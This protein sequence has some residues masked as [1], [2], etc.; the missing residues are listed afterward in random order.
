MIKVNESEIKT[1]S[2]LSTLLKKTGL[3]SHNDLK[4][5]AIVEFMYEKAD[6]FVEIDFVKSVETV[7]ENFEVFKM[8][9]NDVHISKYDSKVRKFVLESL[10]I[11]DIEDLSESIKKNYNLDF[12]NIL[13]GLNINVES[14]EFK[15]LVESIDIST[16]VDTTKVDDVYNQVNEAN[17]YYNSI[18]VSKRSTVENEFGVLLEKESKLNSEK[19]RF[20]LETKKG[21]FHKV[22]EGKELDKTITM[23]NE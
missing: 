7:N 1:K 9:N 16:V 5:R 23:L 17:K 2:Q 15:R 12:D 22:P 14:L 19:V 20:L 18:P 6:S 8:A 4:T 10:D 13:E 3:I 21:V 11:E